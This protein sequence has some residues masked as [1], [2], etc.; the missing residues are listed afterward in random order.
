MT[1]LAS[2]ADTRIATDL[3]GLS[4]SIIDL[5]R[6]VSRAAMAERT[7]LIV[8]DTGTG[9]ELVARALHDS[10]RRAKGPF[11][12]I[13]CAALPESLID[14]ELFGHA[15]GAYTGA[16]SA[17]GGLV[18]AADGGTL[19]LDE[20]NSLSAQAQSKMLRFLESGEYRPVGS[21]HQSCAD[22]WV[23]AAT[24]E[25]L[26]VSVQEH[27][28]REDLYHR[29]RV[30]R[31]DV[32]PLR[33]RGQ[34]ILLL[35]E[36]FLSRCGRPELHFNDDARRAMVRSRW[37]GNVRELKNRVEFAAL[38]CEGDCITPAELELETGDDDATAVETDVPMISAAEP[39][40]EQMERQLWSL[41]DDRGLTL[42][43]AV[44]L[45]EKIM[46][47]EAL[48]AAGDNRT[49]AASRLGIHV[50]TIF[51]KLAT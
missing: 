28:F 15:R 22:T 41:I 5:K 8:G 25:D 7:T 10:S 42:G 47:R 34:D 49:R 6:R 44:G 11:V 12:V 14:A 27:R 24:N 16:A 40:A 51:K 3:I 33:S 37:S 36:H 21:D 9:K 13:N 20:V 30:V 29:L 38:M 1:S 43:E 2:R 35:A 45:C 4:P 17:R 46:I 31:L 50:R 26:S 18:R 19:F 48:R 32:P 39:A 23:V